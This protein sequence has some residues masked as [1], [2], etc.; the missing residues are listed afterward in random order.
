M[1]T[2]TCNLCGA[3]EQRAVY[4]MPDSV[5]HEDEYFTVVECPGCGLGFLN[6]RP[7]ASEMQRYYP[8]EFYDGFD[9]ERD[10]HEGR[11][12]A[13][14]AFIQSVTGT[15]GSRVLLDVGCANGDF[16]RHMR[17]RGW[18]VEGVE[19]SCTS[20]PI[21][22]FEVYRSE[23]PH[24][25]V[26]EPRYDVVTAWAVLEHVHDPMAYFRK[27]SDVLKPN[28]AFIFLVTNFKSASSRHLFRE[29][30][31]RHLYFFT[32]ETIREYLRRND[33]RLV[34]A[35]FSGR[36]YQMRPVNWLYRCV[37]RSIR[38]RELE[39]GDVP[40]TRRKFFAERGV[41]NTLWENLRYVAA[42]PFAGID[43]MLVPLYEKYQLLRGTY[44]IATYAAVKLGADQRD[45]ASH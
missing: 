36:I 37:H 18:E 14:A 30:I 19:I 12:R 33:F 23:F 29:D 35:E 11:Y 31:P 9:R 26:H 25:P 42:H 20:R 24:I 22:D 44:G 3:S 34:R 32:E 5:Y 21:A 15:Q 13:E 2:V 16:P 10:F 40:P 28:G 41:R 39:W 27:A 4:S 6:P 1:E 38:G 45:V 8:A 17:T 43:R 7:T